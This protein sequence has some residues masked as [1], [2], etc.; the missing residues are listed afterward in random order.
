MKK[1]SPN[2]INSDKITT[3]FASSPATSL[4]SLGLSFNPSPSTATGI[5]IT[6]SHTGTASQPS[7]SSSILRGGCPGSSGSTWTSSSGF[8]T[9]KIYCAT[10]FPVNDLINGEWVPLDNFDA[11]LEFCASLNDKR[12]F[13]L[14]FGVAYGFTSEPF[15]ACYLKNP[16]IDVDTAE[17]SNIN[18]DSAILIQ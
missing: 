13:T 8:N 5:P 1:L 2:Y 12:N 11:C 9:F 7:P 16:V 17:I 18:V 3:V 14:C 15:G 6:V 10:D 4:N